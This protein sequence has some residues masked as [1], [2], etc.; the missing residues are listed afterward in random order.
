V[1][2]QQIDRDLVFDRL[3]SD[4]GI[5]TPIA[6][7]DEEPDPDVATDVEF[8]RE[9]LPQWQPTKVPDPVQR[10]RNYLY[11]AAVP[12]VFQL[13]MERY[14]A[15]VVFERMQEDIPKEQLVQVLYWIALHP[16]DGDDSAVDQLWALRVGH[17]RPDMMQTRDRV[18]LYAVKLLGRVTGHIKAD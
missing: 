6:P 17:G 10:A 12:D 4:S 9:N 1:T 2:L 18:A 16:A 3:P 15:R 14:I 8:V 13:P 5:V 11:V 7:A